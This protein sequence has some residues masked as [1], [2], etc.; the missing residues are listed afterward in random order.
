MIDMEKQSPV[1]HSLSALSTASAASQD[2]EIRRVAPVDNDIFT[3]GIS[4][5]HVNIT[6]YADIHDSIGH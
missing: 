5:T 2:Q 3:A 6:S 1:V 4:L